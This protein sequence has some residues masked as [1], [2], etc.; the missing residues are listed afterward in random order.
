MTCGGGEGRGAMMPWLTRSGELKADEVDIPVRVVY[1]QAGAQ[2]WGRAVS[3]V[4]ALKQPAMT[5]QCLVSNHPVLAQVE[6]KFRPG[7]LA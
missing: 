7:Q 5:I 4:L 1:R 6:K 2:L 3:T